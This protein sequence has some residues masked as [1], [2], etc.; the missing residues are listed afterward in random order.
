MKKLCA[1][2][3]LAGTTLAV[4]R[5]DQ[6]TIQQGQRSFAR[7]GSNIEMQREAQRRQYPDS[8][9]TTPLMFSLLAPV[10]APSTDWDVKGFRLGIFAS[11]CVNF[12]GFDL[13][14]LFGRTTGRGNG[15][16]IAG[17]V[18]YVEGSGVG[19]QIAPVAN[20]VNGGYAGFQLGLVNYA[21]TLPGADGKGMQIGF[22]NGATRYKG[23]Q[24][25]VINYTEMIYGAQIGAVNIIAKK[26]WSFLP[27]FNAAF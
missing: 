11:E 20:I 18:N 6:V 13:N 25:G 2:L 3:L 5:A 14:G 23:L 24:I 26:D 17:L 21:G 1:G 4:C 7:T 15:L 10:Q 22:F 27:L 8:V 9:D 19:F 16:Q 12:D